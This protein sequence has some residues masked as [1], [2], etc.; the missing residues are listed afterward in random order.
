VS[1]SVVTTWQISFEQIREERLSAA[2]LLSLMSFF[3]PRGIPE[4]VLRS[5]ARSTVD[6]GDEAD[7][8]ADDEEDADGEFDDD[9][10]TLRAYSLV[11]ATTEGDMWEMHQ[12][13]QFGTRVWLS[14]FG[15]VERWRQK[16][17][18]LMSSEFPVGEFENWPKCQKLLP[19]VE[20]LFSYEPADEGL[21]RE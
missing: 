10:E 20:P 11:T 7:D 14:S 19:H 8:E 12:L 2:D 17:C 13:V 18:R 6:T 1:N 9:L 3:N 16:F 4:S 5:H 21:L 15:D